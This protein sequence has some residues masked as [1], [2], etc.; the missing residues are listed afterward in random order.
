M[1][2]NR[3]EMLD[4]IVI[5]QRQEEVIREEKKVYAVYVKS[6]IDAVLSLF[7][8]T[9]AAIPMAIVAITIKITSPGPIIFKQ[10]RIG[11][12]GE[13][14]DIYKFRTM[15]VGSENLKKSLTAKELKEFEKNYKLENDP[16]VTKIGR[17]LRKTSLDELPQLI[18]ILIG[19]MS[20][21]GPRPLI[22]QELEKYGNQSEKLLSV[23]PGLTGNW[24][25]NGRSDISYEERIELELA[26]VD[27]ISAK[28]DAKIIWRTALGVLGQRGAK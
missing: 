9:I 24:A 15:R 7:G 5:T 16:R 28:F 8:I 27:N 12:N 19:D 21:V 4:E 25:C 17:I 6:I 11:K 10:K 23:K 20:V 14:F 2:S 22:R 18:N 3:I 13:V 1:S 26:Y